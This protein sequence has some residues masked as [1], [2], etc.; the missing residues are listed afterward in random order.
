MKI[1]LKVAVLAMLAV[2]VPSGANAAK[3][4]KCVSATGRITYKRSRC[5]D[6]KQKKVLDHKSDAERRQEAREKE[7]GQMEEEQAARHQQAGAR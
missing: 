6:D 4:N 2:A 1:I 7:R 3:L 5:F